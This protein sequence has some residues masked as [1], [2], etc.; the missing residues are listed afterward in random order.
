MWSM[1]YGRTA[2]KCHANT[3]LE[4]MNLKQGIRKGRILKDERTLARPR[5]GARQAEGQQEQR[6]GGMQGKR[7][8]AE[9]TSLAQAG[10]GHHTRTHGPARACLWNGTAAPDLTHTATEPPL[11]PQGSGSRRY[12]ANGNSMRKDAFV[13][14]KQHEVGMGGVRR[15]G[16]VGSLHI[17]ATGVTQSANNTERCAEEGNLIAY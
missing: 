8:Q 15:E 4:M 13:C 7:W 12:S 16:S 5:S 3:G 11:R 6:P 10:T 14:C 1:C 2:R 17:L 9:G